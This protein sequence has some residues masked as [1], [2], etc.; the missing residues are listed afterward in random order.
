MSKQY[1]IDFYI[2]NNS[3]YYIY[4]FFI[5]FK[6]KGYKRFGDGERAF[7]KNKTRNKKRNNNNINEKDNAIIL[8]NNRDKS[9]IVIGDNRLSEIENIIKG[10]EKIEMKENIKLKKRNGIK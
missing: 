6:N 9:K 1:G 3:N 4:D 5:N 2:P 7:Y 10:R 8:N